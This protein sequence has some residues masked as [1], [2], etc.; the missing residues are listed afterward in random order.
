MKNIPLTMINENLG[1][2]QPPYSLPADYTVRKF[3]EGDREKWAEIETAA[4]EFDTVSQASD[5]FQNEFGAHLE[6]FKDRC[7]F[8]LTNTGEIIGTGTAWYNPDFHGE[9][10]GRVHW[11]AIHPEYQGKNLAKPFLSIVLKKLSEYHA[12]AYLKTQ[13][14]SYKAV[15]IYLDFG[16]EPLVESYDCY[17]GW[18]V[19][20]D[21]LDHP[22]LAG[23][24]S[25]NNRKSSDSGQV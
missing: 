7:L 2:L 10:W 19:L 24:K 13:T 23:F 6:E 4:G 17:E 5:H 22:A 25:G 21:M 16:F 15:K 20:A 11:I 14:T 9:T 3:R 12:K 1:T 8:L 18:G